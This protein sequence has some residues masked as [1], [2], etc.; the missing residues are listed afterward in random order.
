MGLRGGGC[1]ENFTS[2]TE[3]GTDYLIYRGEIERILREQGH[4][5]GSVMDRQY[6]RE[7]NQAETDFTNAETES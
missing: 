6:G 2:I 4:L 7:R 3:G 1:G 5:H